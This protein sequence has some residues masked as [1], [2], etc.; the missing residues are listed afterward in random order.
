MTVTGRRKSARKVANESLTKNTLII[1]SF[2][3][4]VD[5]TMGVV[6]T[7]CGERCRRQSRQRHVT[8]KQEF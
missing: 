6:S 7:C 1:L 8:C 4:P 2:Q 5:G 3:P